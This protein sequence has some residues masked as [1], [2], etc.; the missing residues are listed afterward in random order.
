MD[1]FE[2]N[3][4]TKLLPFAVGGFGWQVHSLVIGIVVVVLFIG[5][6]IAS[7][8]QIMASENEDW[9]RRVQS[10]KWI[11]FIIFMLGIAISGASTDYV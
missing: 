11:I 1:D 10:R 9:I 3:P 7:N 4:L 8:A 5:V 6:V 2:P